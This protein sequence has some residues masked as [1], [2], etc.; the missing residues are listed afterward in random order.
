M[1]ILPVRA[2][3]FELFLHGKMRLCVPN[4]SR[5]RLLH[6]NVGGL[7]ELVEALKR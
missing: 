4:K 3:K 2:A 1:S 7:C 6:L 5:V